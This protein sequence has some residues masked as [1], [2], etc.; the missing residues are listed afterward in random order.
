MRR[1]PVIGLAVPCR[2]LHHRQIGREEFQRPR[3]LLHAR[4]VAADHG[5]AYRRRFWPCRHR[6][7]QIGD[8]QPLGA[9]GNIGKGQRAAGSQQRGGRFDR[10]L[11]AS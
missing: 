4:T 9:L 8:D 10:R 11:H 1:H 2:K 3:E 6:A 5:K 7:R